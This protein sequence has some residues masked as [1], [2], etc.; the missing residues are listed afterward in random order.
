VKIQVEGVDDDLWTEVRVIALRDR[1]SLK[2]IVAEALAAWVAAHN[3]TPA[4]E[5]GDAGHGR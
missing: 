3:G 2:D 5:R 4:T 1:R